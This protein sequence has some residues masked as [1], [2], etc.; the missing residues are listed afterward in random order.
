VA[1]AEFV[2]FHPT[3]LHHP[4]MP[5]PL[6]SEALRGHGAILRGMGGRRFVD[7][8]AP[9]DI[10]SRAIAGEMAETGTENVWLDCTG[11]E[12]FAHRFP[13]IYASLAE[14]GLEPARDWLPVAPAAHHLSGGVLTDLDGATAM[15]GL[16]AAGETACSGVHGANRL[17]SNSLLEGMVFGA[18]VVDAIVSGRS[19]AGDSERSGALGPHATIPLRPLPDCRCGASASPLPTTAGSSAADTA[20]KR[21]RLQAVLTAQAGVVRDAVSLKA[22]EQAI[23]E[24]AASAPPGG[25]TVADAELVNL[26]SL[27]SALVEA[28]GQ[29]RESRGAHTR[30]DFPEPSADF[31]VRFVHGGAG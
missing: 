1:D 6:V 21:G 10:V 14:I 15:A 31:L 5:R 29:R 27:A 20:A 19:P 12:G 4:A 16:W 28:A 7:E 24:L 26:L 2:Q 9:R 23:A 30:S 18:R 3:A 8:L 17:A 11:L 13:T 22:A 25:G